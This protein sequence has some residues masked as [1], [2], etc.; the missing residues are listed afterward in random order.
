M[1]GIERLLAAGAYDVF[2]TRSRSRASPAYRRV[3]TMIAVPSDDVRG[4]MEML[5]IGSIDLA[6]ARAAYAS[7]VQ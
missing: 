6:N 5:S 2:Q 1:R 4:S 3:A 7:A